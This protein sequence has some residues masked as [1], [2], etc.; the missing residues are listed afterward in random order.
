MESQ[1]KFSREQ[2][3]FNRQHKLQLQ[4]LSEEHQR[5]MARQRELQESDL[6]RQSEFVEVSDGIKALMRISERLVTNA[7][8]VDYIQKKPEKRIRDLEEE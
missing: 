5:F 8:M 6:L 3:E 7:E 1:R 4:E 2:E